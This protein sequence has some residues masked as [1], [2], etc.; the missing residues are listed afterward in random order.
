MQG[1]PARSAVIGASL[2]LATSVAT[3]YG[4]VAYLGDYGSVLQLLTGAVI[5]ALGAVAH[6]AVCL[7]PALRQAGF[8]RRA[9]VTWL[10][11]Y[12]PFFA[13]AFVLTPAKLS[14]WDAN[15]WSDAF[16]ILA[17]YTGLPMIALAMLVAF[18]T[19]TRS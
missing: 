16:K 17:L 8:M 6:V 14:Q 19:S 18:V 11:A 7:V 10:L 12:I 4:A 15:V 5:G 2:W 13:L 3:G 9:L 1:P